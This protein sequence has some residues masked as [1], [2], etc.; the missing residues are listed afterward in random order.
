MIIPA[1]ISKESLGSRLGKG[2]EVGE[3]ASKDDNAVPASV[4]PDSKPDS[5]SSSHLAPLEDTRIREDK[6]FL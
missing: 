6:P 5:P 3:G 2:G 1:V 4:D